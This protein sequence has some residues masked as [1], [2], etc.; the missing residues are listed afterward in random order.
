MPLLERFCSLV[1]SIVIAALVLNSIV[2][3]CGPSPIATTRA[4]LAKIAMTLEGCE[5]SAGRLGYWSCAIY[6]VTE[7]AAR[8]SGINPLLDAFDTPIHF[9]PGLACRGGATIGL[10]SNG[11]DRTDN[12]GAGDDIVLR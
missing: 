6:R 10:Y 5:T 1:L 11:P 4:Q 3:R 7:P 8:R 12:C 2:W 9:T